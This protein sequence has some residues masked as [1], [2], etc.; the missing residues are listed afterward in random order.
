MRRKVF[1]TLACILAAVV[2]GMC[3]SA[4]TKDGSGAGGQGEV[5]VKF[6]GESFAAVRSSLTE[7]PDSNDFILEITGS[8]GSIVY[9]GTY[10]KSPET[11]TAPA[12]SCVI[13]VRSG[14]FSTP[15]FSAPLYGDDQVIVVPSGGV[16]DVSLNCTQL[17]SGISLNISSDFLTAYPSGVLYVGSDDGKLMY[18]YT[19]KR[20]AYFMPGNISVI[21]YDSGKE[22]ALMTRALA[23]K[24]ML[25]VNISVA[26]TQTSSTGGITMQIDTTRTWDEE[27]YV[28][29][30][31]NSGK[32]TDADNAMSVSEAKAN[33]G[34]SDVWVTGYIVGGDLTSSSSGISFET[35]FSSATHIA[36]AARASVDSKSSCLSVQLPSG[37]VRDGLNLVSNPELLGSQVCVCGDIT[38][39]YYGIVGI[40]NVSDYVL[41]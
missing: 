3:F 9:S 30:G 8:D 27:N 41:K 20:I 29:G 14:E 11:I 4:C 33:I 21:L 28:L 24:E 1:A 10:G 36:I 19:E 25:T 26:A 18:S 6:E 5:R 17:N 23:A 15:K 32:G 2:L 7:V 35:P 22:T 16:V 13:K 34:A 31:D 40:K 12:G 38:A 39:T 37:D